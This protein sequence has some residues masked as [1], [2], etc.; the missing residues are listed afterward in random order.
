MLG[1][2][3]LLMLI[4]QR[5]SESGALARVEAA[6]KAAF[7]NYLGTSIL[8]TGLFYGWGLGWFGTLSRWQTYLV[9]PVV[10]A[11][12]LL[13]SKLWLERYRYGPLE[14]LWRSLARGA[15]QPMRK[16]CCDSF[17]DKLANDSQ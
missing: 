16:S 6:G 3:A 10:W 8:M 2:A 5:F 12:M 14:W 17:A 9:V 13:W 4:I 15:F 1:H 7:S 11:L